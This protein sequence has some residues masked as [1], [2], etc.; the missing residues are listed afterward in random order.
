MAPHDAA[1]VI[2]RVTDLRQ[3]EY[4]QAAHVQQEHTMALIRGLGHV[5]QA[6]GNLAKV[7]IR[8]MGR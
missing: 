8:T 1:E 3:R 2:R 4:E 6:I 5:V 7:M